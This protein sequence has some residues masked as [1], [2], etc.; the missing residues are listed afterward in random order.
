MASTSDESKI[1]M[2]SATMEFKR[3]S[4]NVTMNLNSSLKHKMEQTLN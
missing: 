1:N 4:T 2:S 3:G